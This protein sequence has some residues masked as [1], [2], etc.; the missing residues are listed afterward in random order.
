MF[1]EPGA[2]GFVV[3]VCGIEKCHEHVDVEEGPH[4]DPEIV[5][6]DVHVVVGHRP[7]TLWQWCKAEEFA[8]GG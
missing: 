1:D 4:S 7:A 5:A 8:I 3:H 2:A 6:Q